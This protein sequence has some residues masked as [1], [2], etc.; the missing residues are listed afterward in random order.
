MKRSEMVQ[1]MTERWL[2]LFHNEPPENMN[3]EE[4]YPEVLERMDE[5][6]K[7]LEYRGML[8]PI[9]KS[10]KQYATLCKWDIE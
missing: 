5:L 6:L 10:A 7:T 4:F 1:Y 8:P 3:A 9:D 2:G